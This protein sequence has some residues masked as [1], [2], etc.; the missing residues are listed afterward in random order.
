M[1]AAG[2]FRLGTQR[3]DS[4]NYLGAGVTIPYA[5]ITGTVA[6]GPTNTAAVAHTTGM[7][8]LSCVIDFGTTATAADFFY[9]LTVG[10]TQILNQFVAAEAQDAATAGRVTEV[11]N[12]VFIN[13]G[14][15]TTVNAVVGYGSA[16]GAM[17][18]GTGGSI[19]FSLTR[20]C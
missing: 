4:A 13:A 8:V 14:A 5:A 7:Y 12:I 11:D 10:G 1:S 2:L 3:I 15:A 17:V 16:S 18:L 19:T 9:T 6:A 20:I